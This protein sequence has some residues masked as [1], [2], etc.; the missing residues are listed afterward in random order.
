MSDELLLINM[1]FLKRLMLLYWT[2][3]LGLSAH[4]WTARLSVAPL[5]QVTSAAGCSGNISCLLSSMRNQFTV[6]CVFIFSPCCRRRRRAKLWWNL[7]CFV[8]CEVLL[9]PSNI[10]AQQ[11]VTKLLWLDSIKVST[12]LHMIP[13]L[14]RFPLEYLSLFCNTTALAVF[15]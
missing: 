4:L 14:S 7:W 1:L 8:F 2:N 3:L 11:E 15:Y 12:V 5:V 9:N 10:T 13:P 6:E